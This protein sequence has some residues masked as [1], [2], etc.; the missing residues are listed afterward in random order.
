MGTWRWRARLERDLARSRPR[1][2]DEY[3]AS[4]MGRFQ[5]DDAAARQAP[6]RTR[7]V[8]A[9]AVTAALVGGFALLGGISHARI[10]ATDAVSSSAG[11]VQ[12]AFDFSGAT[13]SAP[14]FLLA[15]TCTYVQ[16]APD[17]FVF[18]TVGSQTAGTPFNV[19]I[20]A[21]GC[22]PGDVVIID[23]SYAGDKTLTW[24]GTPCSPNCPGDAPDGTSPLYPANPVHFTSG[25]ATVSITLFKAE[26]PRLGVSDGTVSG[27]SNTFTVDAGAVTRLAFTDVS[28]TSANFASAPP[29]LFGCSITPAGNDPSW[30]ADV[31]ATD[32][33]GNVGQNLGS[34][35]ALTYTLTGTTGLTTP[36]GSTS[37]PASGAATTS[38]Q[39]TWSH[40]TSNYDVTIQVTGGSLSSVQVDIHKT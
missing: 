26:S 22:A 2:R 25:M 9:L 30:A 7:R 8:A 38:A 20:T 31:S 28:F 6:G 15:A 32:A 27:S 10:A 23:T 14:R 3:V 24:G 37:I 1:P 11:A 36:A 19:T 18:N 40:G 4:T 33:H 35:V 13:S 16:G 17:T 34:S 39:F 21:L 5:G 12:R 29:C